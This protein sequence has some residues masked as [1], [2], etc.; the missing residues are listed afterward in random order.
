M[1]SPSSARDRQAPQHG[2]INETGEPE[3]GLLAAPPENLGIERFRYRTVMDKAASRLA[4]YFHY[5]QFQFVS[6]VT[7]NY[8]IGVAIADIRYLG[9]AFCYLYDRKA[10]TLVES[11]WLKPPGTGY[12]MTPSPQNGEAEIA[13]RNGAVKFTL[14]DGQWRVVI[15]TPAIKADIRLLSMDAGE[16]L[17]LCTPTGYNGWTYTQKH[18][19]L[20]PVGSLEVNGRPETLSGALA[21]YD[22][23]AGYMRRET[24]WRW[25]SINAELAEGRLGLNLAAGVNET[26]GSENAF[27]LG[28]RRHLLGPVHFTFSRSEAETGSWRIHSD[29]GRVDLTF[30]PLNLRSQRL[31]L[32]LLQSNFRQYI[33]EFSGHLCDGEGNKIKLDRVVGLT[34]DHYARW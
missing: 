3:F 4:R 31:N 14:S 22:F 7:E 18:N 32:W 27:W 23:S 24:S 20:V 25:S 26:G 19:A 30:T 28:G 15:D 33:G 12:R 13:G 5:K 10:N 17:A 21:G 11:E 16:P 6:L 8:L 34:E 1:N 29:D 2:L 9:S